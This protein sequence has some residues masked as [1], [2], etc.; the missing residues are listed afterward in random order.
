M[1]TW[2]VNFFIVIVVFSLIV[3][4]IPLILRFVIIQGKISK[5]QARF[6]LILHSALMLFV[7][8]YLLAAWNLK[9]PYLVAVII[10]AGYQSSFELLT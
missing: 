2:I 3:H 4:I 1:M 10:I 5:K 8:S 9:A 6:L 7:L